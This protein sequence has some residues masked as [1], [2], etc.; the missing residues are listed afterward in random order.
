MRRKLICLA[1]IF[2]FSSIALAQQLPETTNTDTNTEEKLIELEKMWA[3]AQLL[4]DANAINRLISPNFIDIEWDG[5][6]NGR[7]KFLADIRDPAYNPSNIN[8]QNVLVQL[9]GTTAIVTGI[10]D[11]KGS[12]KNRNYE[13]L[14][15]FTDTWI[16][17]N[18]RWLCVVS[19]TNL[20]NGR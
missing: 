6:V 2:L 11:V 9:Y 13:H 7:Q 20:I 19:Q 5:I 15:R 17:E 18:N 3:Q 14:G 16:F 12:Y 4:H 10:Y 1:L 8:I